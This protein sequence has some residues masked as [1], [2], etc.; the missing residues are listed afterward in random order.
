MRPTLFALVSVNHSAPS[1]P[2]VMPDGWLSVVRVGYSVI[3]PSAAMR[4]ILLVPG[5]ANHIAP[6][7]PAAIPSG[8]APAVGIVYS[9]IVAACAVGAS[10]PAA[11]A[12][13]LNAPKRP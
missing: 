1:G 6:S 11:N 13:A 7:G 10:S 12:N 9:L 8:V 5:S 4:P 3:F 2:A